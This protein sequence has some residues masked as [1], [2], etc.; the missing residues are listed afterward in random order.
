MRPAP[1]RRLSATAGLIA[2][3]PVAVLL[4]RGD[5]ALTDAAL[6]AAAVLTAV[7]ALTS[8]AGSGLRVLL[9]ALERRAALQQPQGERAMGGQAEQ[10]QR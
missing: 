4:V 9:R 7:L 3:V 10:Q 6:R 1:V 8:I 5:L 2:L